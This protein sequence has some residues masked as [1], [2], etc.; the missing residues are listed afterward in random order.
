MKNIRAEDISRPKKKD[1]ITKG[2]PNTLKEIYFVITISCFFLMDYFTIKGKKEVIWNICV[3]F[4]SS[5]LC[6]S[7]VQLSGN[8]NSNQ[9]K[10]SHLVLSEFT[11]FSYNYGSKVSVLG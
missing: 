7:E 10:V 2:A 6:L 9:Q 1:S 11:C 8:N 5:C 4:T 3:Y